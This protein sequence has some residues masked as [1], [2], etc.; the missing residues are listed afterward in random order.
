[1]AEGA[2]GPVLL[3]VERSALGRTWR[4]RCD[5]RA[6]ALALAHAQAHG[7]SDALARV[8]AGRNVPLEG[9]PAFLEPRLRDLMPDPYVL[10]DMET[11]ARRLA[12]AIRRR[13]RVAIFGDYDVDGATSSALLGD[14]LQYCGAPFMVHI[15]DRV[16]EGYGPNSEAIRALRRQG[17]TL[18]VTVDCGAASHE[19]FETAREVGFDVVVL[20]HHQ[21]PEHLPHALALVNPN[22]QDDLSG[23]GY[24]CAAGVTFLALVA[25]NRILREEGFW[26]GG[27]EPDL[28]SGLDLVALGTVADVAPL[29]GLN[30]AFV[31]QGLQV[32]R[33]R[34]RPG[35]TALVDVARLKG[36]PEAWHMGYLV[37][38][39]INAGGRIGDAA[40]GA[41]LLLTSDP[42]EAARIAM[43]LD[44]L[45]RQRQEIEQQAV[46]EAAAETERRLA[47]TPGMRAIVLG[48]PEWHPGVVGLIA[49]R[50][51]E[52]FG[53]PAFAFAIRADGVATGSG[54]SVPGVDL[55]RLARLAV[56]RGVAAKGGGHAMAA[57]VTVPADGLEAFAAFLEEGLA[58]DDIGAHAAELLLDGT[59]SAAGAQPALV[60]MLERAGPY[61]A[62]NP[63]PLF[64]LPRLRLVE[65]L[66]VGAG[67]VR[68]RLK[69]GDG[70]EIGGVAFRALGQP[71]GDALAACAGRQVH[72]AGS[73]A[74]NSWGGREKAE[75]RLVDL[76]PARDG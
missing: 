65:A 73:L 48:S 62:G 18:L 28:M 39:R 68:Y 33:Q 4:S 5:A 13:E 49:S 75:L 47:A 1:M 54:R 25:V 72:V 71:L 63:E 66:P 19:A 7:L 45:N 26:R 32:M 44:E 43:E 51:K 29:V 22:R 15:P 40:L 56:E 3:G 67:H 8:L 41:R 14:F 37:G 53:R 17:A 16:T 34:R 27:R 10:R 38:P 9:A 12:D 52:R 31:R 11:A 24:L 61:G 50:L 69:A 35:L 60:S 59:L 23:L 70:A 42:A 6:E 64:A 74:I 21:A 46:E 30:R 55:G 57:G 20:D 36:P 2:R 58:G 76:A